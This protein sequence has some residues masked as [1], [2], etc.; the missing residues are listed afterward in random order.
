[1]KQLSLFDPI[2]PPDLTES[3]FQAYF[4]CRRN[5]RNT[6]NALQFE[7]HFEKYI[8]ELADDIRNGSYQPGRSVAFIVTKPVKRE[9][10]A[11]QFRDRIVHHWLIGKL[12]PFFERVFIEDAY[13]CRTGKGTHYG[14][15]R[16]GGFI[17]QC[18]RE[19]HGEAYVLKLDIRG[20]FMHISRPLLFEKL[21]AFI[22]SNEVEDKV[23]ILD[24]AKRII[25]N[26]PTENCFIKGDQSLWAD[27]PKDKS[28]FH[29]PLDCGLPIGNLTSQV[30]ANFYLN[31]LDHFI[32]ENLCINYYGRYVDDFVL[33]HPDR[34]YLASLVPIIENYLKSSLKLP[35]HPKK[36]YLQ[37]YSKGLAFL[38]VMIKPN[39]I[40]IG[41]RIKA[42]CYNVLNQQNEI[43][44]T[45]TIDKSRV[46][47]FISQMNSY[48]GIMKHYHT[49]RL[50]QH[51]IQK[52]MDR[53]WWK[54]IFVKG[55][56]VAFGRMKWVKYDLLPP[57]T[58]TTAYN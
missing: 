15:R 22:A 27:L 7:L 1:M 35:L 30:F 40:Y 31:E 47:K 51:I 23:F 32:K 37:H 54:F 19:N 21:E 57:I 17:E 49:F 36:R 52:K 11:A 29:S 20:F 2:I 5:K 14:I 50:R 55:Q 48:L 8:F 16:V 3:L 12:N 10:F 43:V 58:D 42:N 45:A 13:A 25:F 41:N 4:D 6:L 53:R 56:Y 24:I 38:G 39:R 33:V 46:M 44:N 34:R 9:V 18:A 26:H 28:L